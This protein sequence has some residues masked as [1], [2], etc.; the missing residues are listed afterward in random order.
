MSSTLSNK[1]ILLAEDDVVSNDNLNYMLKKHFKKVHSCYSGDEAY[2]KYIKHKPDVIVTDIEMPNMN[3]LKLVE[4]IRQKDTEIPVVIMTS[5]TS[6]QYLLKAVN[7]YLLSYVVKPITR[8]NF[9]TTINKL[10]NYFLLNE[11]ETFF[12]T[13]EL[14][15]D[16]AKKVIVESKKEVSLTHQ[17]I[18]LLEEFIQKKNSI[19]SNQ[20]LEETL[21][22][23]YSKSSNA[24][25]LAISRLRKKLPPESIKTVYGEGYILKHEK[26]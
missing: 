22:S 9:K 2:E 4:K 17:E 5:F 13:P 15:Y 23:E 7:M 1:T 19:L 24:L 16:Y 8:T 3:G 25:K 11:K 10:E 18:S 21:G 14:Y 12:F 6:E 20:F 26:K